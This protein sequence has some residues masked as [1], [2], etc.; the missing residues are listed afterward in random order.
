M[1]IQKIIENLLEFSNQETY[2]FI[3]ANLIETIEGAL[4]LVARSL[5]KDQVEVIRKYAVEPKISAS[6][7]HLK[8]VWMNFECPDAVVGYTDRP[9]V[10]IRPGVSTRS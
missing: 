7:S 9:V 3:E 8:L 4:A 1:R 5:K 6:V 2:F 10:S